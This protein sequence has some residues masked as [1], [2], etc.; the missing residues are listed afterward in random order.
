MVSAALKGNHEEAREFHYRLMPLYRT[1]FIE[2]NPIPLKAAMNHFNRP[3]GPCRLP[4][5]SLTPEN[6]KILKD[7]LTRDYAP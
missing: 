5:C 7:V 6:E 1:M 2:T 3:A 4:L